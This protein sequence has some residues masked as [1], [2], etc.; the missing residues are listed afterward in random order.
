VFASETAVVRG[1]VFVADAF[2][3]MTRDALGETACV[4]KY[5]CSVVLANELGQAIVD[6][7]PDLALHHG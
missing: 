3:E 1:D 4:N 7:V 6:F 2:A 5:E